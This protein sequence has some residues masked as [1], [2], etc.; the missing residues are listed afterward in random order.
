VLDDV[1]HSFHH[2]LMPTDG[3]DRSARAIDQGMQFAQQVG[4]RVTGLHVMG[5][6]EAFTGTAELLRMTQEEYEAWAKRQSTQILEVILRAAGRFG[7]ACEVSSVFGDR[8]WEA[9]ID[10]AR[11]EGCDLIIMASHGRHGLER[12]L[13]GSETEKVMAHVKIP[14]MVI[15]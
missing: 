14:V 6:F 5:E 15:R 11:R 2:L 4:A 13:L 7:V 12:V 1:H 8:P 10:A 9:I 3:S